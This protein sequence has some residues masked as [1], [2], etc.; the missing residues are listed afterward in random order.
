MQLKRELEF[1]KQEEEK[2]KVYIPT[3]TTNKKIEHL[4]FSKDK[5]P[6]MSEFTFKEK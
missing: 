5:Q 1:I 2:I 4:T 3:T 6:S